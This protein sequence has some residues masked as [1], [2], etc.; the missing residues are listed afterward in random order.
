MGYLSGARYL[1]T[2]IIPL[3][4]HPGDLQS[5]S[6]PLA[7]GHARHR[8]QPICEGEHKAFLPTSSQPLLKPLAP[9]LTTSFFIKR[10]GEGNEPSDTVP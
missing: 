2:L 10:Q 7:L 8:K 6:V 9:S 1:G 4:G 3:P 5:T